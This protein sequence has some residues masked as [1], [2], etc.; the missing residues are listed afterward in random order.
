[1]KVCVAKS[2]G[3]CKGVQNAFDTALK[4]AKEKGKIYTIGALIHN[5]GVVQYLKERGVE[6]LSL[7]EAKQL[8]A[9]SVALIRAHGIPWQDEE[10]MRSRGIELY[11]ATCP[12]VKR[13]HKIVSERYDAGDDIIIVGDKNHDEVAGAASYGRDR[14][15]VVSDS[16]ELPIG[17]NPTRIVLPTPILAE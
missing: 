4:L 5:E 3:F 7:E 12:V 1:M 6:S 2:A 17:D 15:R 14:V 16:G 10:Y 8:P 11:D 13:I 9:G